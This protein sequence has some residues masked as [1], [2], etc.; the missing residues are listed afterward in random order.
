ME[1]LQIG[2]KV[3]L[4]VGRPTNIGFT[5]LVDQAY[6]GML[7]KNELF[8]RIEEGQKLVGYVKKV[9]EDG[10][11]DVSLKPIG[12]K[13]AVVTDEI[14]ILN[15]LK[16]KDGFLP[17]NDKSSPDD[18]KYGLE[19]SKKSFKKAIGG[20]YKQKLITIDEEGIHLIN[21]EG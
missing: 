19:M 3:E 18:I 15:E 6:E 9:R 4:L 11:L 2:D 5:V 7:Y 13:K 16:K 8:Q 21:Y 12:F 17:F 14:F 20:L 1:E 10:K